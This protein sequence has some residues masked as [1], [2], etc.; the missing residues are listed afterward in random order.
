MLT[1]MGLPVHDADAAVRRLQAPGGKA[2][3]AIEALFPGSVRGG[4]LDRQALG[5]QVFGDRAAL[6]RLEAAIHP[7]VQAETQA[8]LK[9][10]CRLGYRA[11]VLDVPLLFEGGG[12]ARCDATIV[13]SAPAFIQRQR[14]LARPGM[15]D[16][17]LAGILA[18]QMP[19][20]DKRRL[21]D[22]VIPTGLGKA[23]TLR[24]L[25]QAVR[26]SLTRPIRRPAW[27]PDPHRIRM[28]RLHARNRP[29]YRN[30]R[31]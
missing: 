21:A 3:P 15:T 30:H 7:L 22:F 28:A 12:Q 16:D 29:R 23:A 25:G 5:A 1:R 31:P 6:A 10:C 27:P 19:D 11:V 9:R 24:R 2:L 20:A 13:V 8:F 17:K 4:V 14:V 18:R 26:L